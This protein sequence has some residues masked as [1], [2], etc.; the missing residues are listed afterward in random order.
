[1]CVPESRA[2]WEKEAET[3]STC[4]AKSRG[5]WK[6]CLELAMLRDALVPQLLDGDIRLIDDPVGALLVDSTMPGQLGTVP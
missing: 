6:Q 1:V 5:L 2:S 4:F 3:I